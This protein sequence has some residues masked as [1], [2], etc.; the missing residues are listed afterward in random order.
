MPVHQLFPLELD[1]VMS[2]AS[3]KN[4]RSPMAIPSSGKAVN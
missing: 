3:R 1:T 4:A 2:S